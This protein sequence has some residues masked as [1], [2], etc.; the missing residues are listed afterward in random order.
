MCLITLLYKLKIMLM[1]TLKKEKEKKAV[2]KA[3]LTDE[4]GDE[5]GSGSSTM[6][7]GPLRPEPGRGG[8]GVSA[9]SGPGLSFQYHQFSCDL[10]I[11]NH[12]LSGKT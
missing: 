10:R 9:V 12:A 1:L 11:G 2:P 7:R 8:G 4:E 5:E 6:Q 3:V